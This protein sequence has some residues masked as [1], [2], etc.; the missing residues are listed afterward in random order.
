MQFFH[1]FSFVVIVSHTS[2]LPQLAE[3]SEQYSNSVDTTLVSLFE[4][5]SYQSVLNTRENSVTLVSLERRANSGG[6]SGGNSAGT[7]TPPSPESTSDK[8]KNTISTVFG[9]GAFS[10]MKLSSTIEKVGNG[11]AKLP[12]DIRKIVDMIGG[13]AGKTLEF[14]F[15]KAL[16][17]NTVLQGWVKAPGEN[18]ISIIKSGLG[19]VEY[20]KVEPS[21]KQTAAGL[22][23]KI[24]TSLLIVVK[25][26]SY[27]FKKIGFI[28]QNLEA[29][30]ISFKD[31]F[32]SY[33]MFFEEL[34]P[35]LLRFSA[36]K[37]YHGYLSDICKSLDKF[38]VDQQQAYDIFTI[39][40]KAS[41]HK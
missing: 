10:C 5:I 8:A 1:L 6:S 4:T 25:A 16:Y 19:T 29:V 39:I 36:G 35:I 24:Q 31:I 37:V 17:V 28:S 40:L 32:R 3:L 23:A 27:L 12:N 21:L 26:V 30:H 34:K 14:Y 11:I 18:I 20:P 9:D 33:M 2:A 22:T 7:G 41:P 38:L 15:K 13:D